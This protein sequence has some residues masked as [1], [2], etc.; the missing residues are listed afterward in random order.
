MKDKIVVNG[1]E[2]SAEIAAEALREN[3]WECKIK[4]ADK[5]LYDIGGWRVSVRRGRGGEAF[6]Y[7]DGCSPGN[8][9]CRAREAARALNYAADY[10]DRMNW[11]R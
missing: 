1:A 6:V 2:I 7:V 9:S 3:G 4:L 8:D 5:T 10:C 11:E